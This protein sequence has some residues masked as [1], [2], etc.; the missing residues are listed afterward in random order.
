MLYIYASVILVFISVAVGGV[1]GVF[2]L[3]GGRSS[4]SLLVARWVAVP[5][6]TGYYIGSQRGCPRLGVGVK[7]P[8][9]P[10]WAGA[11]QALATSQQT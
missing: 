8:D 1:A 9:T 6:A 2:G 4:S 10:H 11:C 3:G 7:K 5:C